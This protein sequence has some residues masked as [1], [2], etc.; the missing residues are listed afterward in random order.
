MLNKHLI[1]YSTCFITLC[2]LGLAST[3]EIQGMLAWWIAIA[4]LLPPLL[5]ALKTRYFTLITICSITFFTQF[6][7][8]P[9][10]FL[11]KEDFTFSHIKPF[12]FTALEVA[13]MFLYV[14]VFLYALIILFKLLYWLY[15]FGRTKKIK[16]NWGQT[17]PFLSNKM[18]N[19]TLPIRTDKNKRSWAFYAL[20]ILIIVIV[21]PINL[22]MFSMDIGLTGI[23]PPTLP[24]RLAGF[25]HYATK[26]IIPFVLGYLYWKTKGGWLLMFLLLSYAWIL[27]LSSISRGALII[28]MLPVLVAALLNRQYIMSFVALFGTILGVA[29]VTLARTFIYIIDGNN[30]SGAST[31]FNII[32]IGFNIISDQDSPFKEPDFLLTV[33][34]GI[35]GR[36]E[37]FKS[38]VMANY[39]DLTEVMSPFGFIQ[40]MVWRGFAPIDT[41]LHHLQWQGNILPEGFYNGG[42]LIAN[43]IILG[44]VS[45]LWLP[46]CSAVVALLLVILEK[47]V[48][49]V[50]QKY[51]LP[52]IFAIALITFFTMIFFIE[53]GGS[54]TF[55]YPLLLLFIL[56]FSPALI[57]FKSKD[58]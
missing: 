58:V 42:S 22:W 33:F 32:S 15:P 14:A 46:A 51:N 52:H 24:Y 54:I 1:V 13:P 36:V 39:Y 41:D 57:R 23:E 29:F 43:V 16:E 8:L 53:T 35:V 44:N 9:F 12:G 50:V 34:V 26:F 25:L 10:F 5:W 21:T 7:T 55:V 56:S 19:A 4:F 3:G 45:L 6:I 47:T 28:V 38:L 18:S 30:K 2:S 31:E 11:N 48:R 17:A 27:G 20:I 37:S 40:R 49:V